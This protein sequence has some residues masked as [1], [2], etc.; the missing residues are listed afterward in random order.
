MAGELRQLAL[1]SAPISL[2][3]LDATKHGGAIYRFHSAQQSGSNTL[4][5][6]G[7]QYFGVPVIVQGIELTTRG[8]SRP[9]LEVG[10]ASM[11]ALGLMADFD[12]FIGAT[13]QRVRVLAEHLDGG[14]DP[15]PTATWGDITLVI[16]KL[17]EATARI[18]RYSL[19]DPS[20][21]IGAKLPRGRMMASSC[22]TPYR[23]ETCQY[24]G[25]PLTKP[26]GTA[27]GGGLTDRGTWDWLAGL[28]PA[29]TIRSHWKADENTGTTIAN[30]GASGQLL[31]I[32]NATW[33]AGKTGWGYAVEFTGAT[34]R[35][36]APS[37]AGIAGTKGTVSIWFRT[38]QAAAA[39]IARQQNGAGS[40]S[41]SIKMTATG[42][43]TFTVEA[44]GTG[45]QT[46]DEVVND[47]LWHCATLRW[48]DGKIRTGIDGAYSAEIDA[49]GALST[50]LQ[51]IQIGHADAAENLEDGEF[52]DIRL[53]EEHLSDATLLTIQNTPE[54]IPAPYST[55]D[56][57]ET[58]DPSGV[59]SVYV[60]SQA[61]PAGATPGL[62]GSGQYWD[63][64]T[65]NKTLG[66]CA[67]RFPT[68][69]L[70]YDGFPGL[71][72]LQR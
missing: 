32:Q 19:G 58:E 38:S 11:V 52:D 9:T 29:A 65:C 7:H 33:K 28:V 68:G 13:I 59:P 12:D 64:D 5:L 37:A 57:V 26:D 43:L 31:T 48:K 47:G 41:W 50:T 17:E 60:A 10:L 56:Y 34:S 24:A 44:T 72:E 36:D 35:A 27:F 63:R 15:D 49:A 3:T 67:A 16:S 55:G 23:G 40:S 69:G 46:R 2:Y 45:T 21:A 14:S 62:Y 71:D 39:T 61:V 51:A 25:V 20:D 18:V 1:N 4:H 6:G 53:F 8:K 70:N 30:Q 22:P 42:L 54:A 66:A